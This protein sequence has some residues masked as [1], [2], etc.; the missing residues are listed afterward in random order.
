MTKPGSIMSEQ[1]YAQ[2]KML[3]HSAWYGHLPRGITPSDVDATVANGEFV[4]LWELSSSSVEWFQIATGQRRLY[5]DMVQ[6]SGGKHWACLLKHSVDSSRAIDTV[7]DIDSFHVMFRRDDGRTD[8]LPLQ[9]GGRWFDFVRLFYEC[10]KKA[11]KMTFETECVATCFCGR[12]RGE[13][14]A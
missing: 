11:W 7:E 5:E 2:G 12:C 1:A 14:N 13:D 8:Y 10:R 4:L 3:N 6:C 9:P